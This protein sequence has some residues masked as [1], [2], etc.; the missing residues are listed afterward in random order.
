M[1]GFD[2]F[3][4]EL[5]LVAILMIM[6]KELLVPLM[7]KYVFNGKNG[8][9]TGQYRYNPHP[10]GYAKE[11]IGHGERLGKIETEVINIKEDIVEIRKK[12]D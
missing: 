5:A 1:N 10:P 11:C 12:L 7:K 4:T 9:K 3:G 2:G 6:A 8:L